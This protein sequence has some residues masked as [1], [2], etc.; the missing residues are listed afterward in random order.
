MS[1]SATGIAVLVLLAGPAYAI[2]DFQIANLN[3]CGTEEFFVHEGASNTT[4]T[5]AVIAAMPKSSMDLRVA[6]GTDPLG[7]WTNTSATAATGETL[8]EFTLPSLTAGTRYYYFLECRTTGAS[9]WRRRPQGTF[10]TA[11]ATSTVAEFMDA[12]VADS[13]Q[14]VTWIDDEDCAT[15]SD[16]GAELI[17][18][19]YRK[20]ARLMPDTVTELGDT[21]HFHCNGCSPNACTWR[22]D[23][24]GSQSVAV[25]TEADGRVRNGLY[26]QRHMRRNTSYRYK[27]GNHDG[28]LFGEGATISRHN[29]AQATNAHAATQS[30]VV[31]A[32]DT[33]PHGQAD[34]EDGYYWHERSGQVSRVYLDE[35]I[36]TCEEGQTCDNGDLPDEA[37]DWTLGLA[38]KAFLDALDDSPATLGD[39]VLVYSHHPF[40]TC[41]FSNPYAY[42]RFGPKMTTDTNVGSDWL[43][44][45][46]Y[47]HDVMASWA[48][49][50]KTVIR[51]VGHDHRFGWIASREGV[52][53]FVVGQPGGTTTAWADGDGGEYEE[54][55]DVDGDGTA[56]F[57]QATSAYYSPLPDGYTGVASHD[58]GGYLTLGYS[59]VNSTLVE[60]KWWG[61]S[62]DDAQDDQNTFFYTVDKSVL[63]RVLP[64]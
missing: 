1:L 47:V 34:A 16:P 35:Y 44:P 22:G 29:T 36:H 2:G 14:V 6:Y 5:T 43:G 53:Y 46:E 7:P 4:P 54:C 24:L 48:A 56:D 27:Q 49:S 13:H 26:N 17:D 28:A 38:Q 63:T 55:W 11:Y 60:L 57:L 52:H 3:G 51:L 42:G 45:E 39:V 58:Y 18:K 15:S 10:K 37:D 30:H 12:V 40:G 21:Y 59:S 31:N 19:T 23:A 61:T 8:T 25:L 41:P 32:N 9:T 64:R 33:F 50:G 62:S 20:L